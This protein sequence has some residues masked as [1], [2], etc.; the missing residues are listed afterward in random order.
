M[1]LTI[2]NNPPVSAQM[3]TDLGKLYGHLPADLKAPFWFIATFNDRHIA[4]L[5]LDEDRI[6]N[7][8]VRTETRRRGVGK[9]LLQKAL[10]RAKELGL[11]QVKVVASDY[12]RENQALVGD[13]L[14]AQGFTAAA[15]GL[16]QKAL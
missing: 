11:S 13:F 2:H 4:A 5:R 8:A 9:Y 6:V 1:R 7:L 14:V 12:P 16:W 15:A 3:E 10:E